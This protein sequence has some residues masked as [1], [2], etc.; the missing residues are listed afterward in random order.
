MASTALRL[1]KAANRAGSD[2]N[3]LAPA[4]RSGPGAA[5]VDDGVG[6]VEILR[7]RRNRRR[8]ADQHRAGRR[9]FEKTRANSDCPRVV[10]HVHFRRI[11]DETCC[12]WRS[13]RRGRDADDGPSAESTNPA[14]CRRCR[15]ARGAMPLQQRLMR[16]LGPAAHAVNMNHA[17]RRI[18]IRCKAE[19]ARQAAHDEPACQRRSTAGTL[20]L[21]HSTT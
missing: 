9:A 8:L 11:G 1:L 19:D 17:L 20:P 7:E 2:T 10:R 21:K 4:S 6:P 5:N 18:R 15:T 13:S 16:D 14:V 3:G 12:A